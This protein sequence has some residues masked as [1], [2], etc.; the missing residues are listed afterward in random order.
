MLPVNDIS[1][2]QSTWHVWHTSNILQGLTSVDLN[3]I[4]VTVRQR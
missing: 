1:V 2:Y 3:I 4:R